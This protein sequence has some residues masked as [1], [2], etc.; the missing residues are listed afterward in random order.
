MTV[1]CPQCATEH[2]DDAP[3]CLHPDCGALLVGTGSGVSP[4]PPA[5]TP[6]SG[7][8]EPERPGSPAA[9]PVPPRKYLAPALAG[10]IL[11]LAIV[12]ALLAGNTG[13]K[14][15]AAP[16]PADG[17]NMPVPVLTSDAPSPTATAAPAPT[18]LTAAP[19]LPAKRTTGGGAGQA[20][21]GPAPSGGTQTGNGSGTVVPEP[22]KEK[23]PSQPASYDN[24]RLSTSSTW[25]CESFQDPG[26][27]NVGMW[28]WRYTF[29]V[30][31]TLSGAPYGSNAMLHRGSTSQAM[32]GS[33]TS[34]S[35]TVIITERSGSGAL[36][37]V[38]YT[39]TVA[40][41]DGRTVSAGNFQPNVC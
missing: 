24:A 33:G 7:S 40:V 16:G 39:V 34:F 30:Y 23:T 32:S 8:G 26:G 41:P 27:G 28:T 9:A 2:H 17:G 21:T 4:A 13:G 19:N 10:G 18:T 25:R 20:T 1:S 12:G 36:G 31:A 3:Y 15:Q 29:T 14:E 11:A 38:N 22:R 35:T 6:T 37:G 5:D